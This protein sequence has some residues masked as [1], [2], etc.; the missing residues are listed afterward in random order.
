MSNIVRNETLMSH[1]YEVCWKG[2]DLQRLLFRVSGSGSDHEWKKK[3]GIDEQSSSSLLV[4]Y[5][6]FYCWDL[7]DSK[8]TAGFM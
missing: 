5:R 2:S 4:D 7:L 1:E 6:A 8:F 3:I